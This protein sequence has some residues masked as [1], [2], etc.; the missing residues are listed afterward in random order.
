MVRGVGNGHSPSQIVDKL[1]DGD[2]ILNAGKTVAEVVQYLGIS[3][4]T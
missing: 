4:Q 2:A 3:E 1:R